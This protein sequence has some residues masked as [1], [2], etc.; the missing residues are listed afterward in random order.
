[1]SE[2]GQQPSL[3]DVAPLLAL[4]WEGHEHHERTMAWLTK[5]KKAVCPVTE[6]G[7]LRIS[8]QPAFGAT[9]PQAKRMLRD[10][11]EAEKP[12]FIPC[13]LDALDMDDPS[14]GKHT[15]DFYLANPGSKARDATGHLGR[16]HQAPG[17]LHNSGLEHL[18]GQP[19]A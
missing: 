18:P 3:L 2:P 10:W 4:L 5:G 8:T 7:F 11:K 17:R 13:D 15:T 16:R 14:T 19:A 6:L 9:F 1:M 12:E